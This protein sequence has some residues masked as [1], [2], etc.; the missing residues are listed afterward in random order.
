MAW[1]FRNSVKLMPGVRLNFS[2]RGTSTSIGGAGATL[3]LGRRGATGTVGVPGTGVSYS[4][5]LSDFSQ[6]A[7][8]D[9]SRRSSAGCGA[10]VA[11]LGGLLLLGKCVS[12]DPQPTRQPLDA[13]NSALLAAGASGQT[14]ETG[15]VTA[16]VLNGREHPAATA[17]ILTK[18]HRSE[19]VNVVERKGEWAKIVKGGAAIWIL[20]KHISSSPPLPP[21]TASRPLGLTSKASAVRSNTSRR[22][23]GSSCD[24]VTGNVCIGPRGGRYCITSGGSKRYGR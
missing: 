16:S 10:I 8:G 3:N 7:K 18:L 19:E 12:S 20:A 13:N 17:P 2:R 21:Q 24:C 15:F 11:M 4:R 5:L 23:A 22:R 1:R 9:G 6:E 14:V